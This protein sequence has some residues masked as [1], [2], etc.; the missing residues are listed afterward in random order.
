MT[1]AQSSDSKRA[2]VT[3]PDMTNWF[4]FQKYFGIFL[5]YDNP[6]PIPE[7]FQYMSDIFFPSHLKKQIMSGIYLVYTMNVISESFGH[8]L[9]IHLTYPCACKSAC[10]SNAIPGQMLRLLYA[11]CNP[12]PKPIENDALSAK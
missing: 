5:A 7:M 10:S 11:I 1:R 3:S 9:G 6:I 2:L 12:F 4:I 8:M